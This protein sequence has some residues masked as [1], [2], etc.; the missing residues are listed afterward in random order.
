MEG[1][2]RTPEGVNRYL[3]HIGQ[4]LIEALNLTMTAVESYRIW[5]DEAKAEGADNSARV[6]DA[7]LQGSERG[8][9]DLRELIKAYVECDRWGP[10]EEEASA[11]CGPDACK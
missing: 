11:D 3:S 5:R 1:D 10:D 4:N 6:Y 8:L 9:E 7:L 2:E